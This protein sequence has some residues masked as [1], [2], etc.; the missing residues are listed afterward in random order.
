[1]GS[2]RG[3]EWWRGGCR[4]EV[5]TKWDCWVVCRARGR[6]RGG[7]RICVVYAL[8]RGEEG[9]G[10]GV[11]GRGS[12]RWKEQVLMADWWFFEPKKM[13]GKMCCC[14]GER[15]SVWCKWW[16]NYYA[17]REWETVKM[18][19]CSKSTSLSNFVSQT[20]IR[21]R[22]LSVM[23]NCH[24]RPMPFYFLFLF[25]F[26][27]SKQ[28]QLM[29]I[30]T[31]HEHLSPA[32]PSSKRFFNLKFFKKLGQ[33]ALSVVQLANIPVLIFYISILFIGA[34]K[35]GFPSRKAS[36]PQIL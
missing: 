23:H 18:E 29:S 8:G 13:S 4:K 33:L 17:K 30:T 3:F 32:D 5:G 20:D 28:K 9:E 11:G 21:P 26:F 31:A 16:R 6:G 19:K 7:V 1:M 24:T 25:L 27:A 14:V 2:F 15:W 12:V 35:L 22:W 34:V 10:G 36:I